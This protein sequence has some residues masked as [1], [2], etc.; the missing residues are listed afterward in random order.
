MRRII[1]TFSLT[2]IACIN[3]ALGTSEV[4]VSASHEMGSELETQNSVF[5]PQDID[6]GKHFRDLDV[7]GSILIYDAQ[8]NRTYQ[9]NPERNQ[10]AFPAASTFKILNSMIALETGVI[11][12][13]LSVLTWDGIQRELPQW[14]R[15]LNL[16][17]AFKVSG[18]W[19]YQ[20]LAR[21]VGHGQMDEWMTKVD[22][23][24]QKIGGPESID[25]FWLDGIL[26]VTPQEQ[27]DF[28]QDLHAEKLP[29]SE[30]TMAIV[31]DI[32]I[33]E[34]TPDYTISAKTGWFGFGDYSKPNIGWYVGYVEKDE[35]V[36]FF[37]TNIN[38]DTER[39]AAVRIELTR[40]CL[41]DL[42]IL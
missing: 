3:F 35:N 23:G 8:N 32:M 33:A 7:E 39:D 34:Q 11:N 38:I 21:R 19:F 30:R 2:T 42:G 13:E 9:Y 15:D 5:M 28:L 41:Q 1:F 26:Q 14:N 16:R 18:V 6:F 22:Y 24:N 37:A 12:D 40:R 25:R 17:E 10:T 29:F 36:Y 31:K 4:A 20:V 27:V